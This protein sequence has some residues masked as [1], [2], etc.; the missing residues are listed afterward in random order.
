MNRYKTLYIGDSCK[1]Y[2]QILQFLSKGNT[3]VCIRKIK[4]DG[5]SVN[6]LVEMVMQMNCNIK[7]LVN[8][9][10]DRYIQEF[11]GHEIS[12]NKWFNILSRHTDMIKYPI[13]EIDGSG[14][15]MNNY[16]K[17]TLSPLK[18]DM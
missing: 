7:D 4:S 9:N 18:E 12:E 8:K 13:I 17:M 11:S 2:L 1:S 16:L 14:F 3:P 6:F 10:S 5:T 15:Y